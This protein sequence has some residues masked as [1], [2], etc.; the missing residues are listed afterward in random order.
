M[1]NI[2]T[3]IIIIIIAT[4]VIMFF[5]IFNQDPCLLLTYSIFVVIDFLILLTG[6]ISSVR[7]LFDI[8]V[9]IVI[10]YT[11]YLSF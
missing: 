6:I 10:I 3:T 2:I 7:L 1:I 5:I 11:I 8:Q 9:V 4:I